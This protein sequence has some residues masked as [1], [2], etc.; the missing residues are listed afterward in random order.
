MLFRQLPQLPDFWSE[1]VEKSMPQALESERKSSPVHK[2]F[3]ISR[4]V[5]Q[6][7]SKCCSK[8]AH[9]LWFLRLYE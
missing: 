3:K 5:A 1:M 4:E 2:L 7:F 6:N 8:V 9:L